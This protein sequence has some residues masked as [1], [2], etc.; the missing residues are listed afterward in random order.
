MDAE[1][2]KKGMDMTKSMGKFLAPFIE[3]SLTQVTGMVEDKLK[4]MR[5]ERQVRFIE[6]SNEKMKMLGIT[7][8]EKP[9]P[10]KFA[11]PIFQGASLEENDN[12]QDL[13]S[14]LLINSVANKKI[15]IKRVYMDI[16]ERISP[17]EATIIQ[18]VYT[19]SFKENQHIGLAT[20]CLPEYVYIYERNRKEDNKVPDLD[21]E[22]VELALMNL[23]RIGCISPTKSIGGGELF[24]M[25]NMTL[26]G[27]KFYESCTL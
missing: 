13:W 26:L 12:L 24:S 25:I 27:Y 18:K 23:S 14:N 9:L 4:Y 1:I 7:E 2:I 5:W 17:L 3:G 8:V 20:N 15:E 10:L 16:L 6:R 22:D 19:F 21:N 11:I